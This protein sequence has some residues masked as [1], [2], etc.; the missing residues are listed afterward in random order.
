MGHTIKTLFNKKIKP[1]SDIYST[2]HTVE[3]CENFHIHHRNL[4]ML[5]NKDEFITFCNSCIIA[6]NSWK[7]TGS[8]LPEPDKSLPEYLYNRPINSVHGERPEDFCIEV[9]G[10]LP[11][12]PPNMIHIHLKSLRLDVSHDEFIELAEGFKKALEEFK[13][14]KN[15]SEKTI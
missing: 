4:R 3:R 11:H 14:W 13:E 8:L 6:L 7:S 1:V 10:D 5:F 15:L 2:M 12:M 9:Q